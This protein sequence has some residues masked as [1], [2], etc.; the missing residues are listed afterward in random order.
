MPAGIDIYSLASFRSHLVSASSADVEM[1]PIDSVALRA[2]NAVM[3][4][5]S[6]KTFIRIAKFKMTGNTHKFHHRPDSRARLFLVPRN[7]LTA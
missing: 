6:Y 2:M 3:S 1:N 5:I 4:Y 7:R